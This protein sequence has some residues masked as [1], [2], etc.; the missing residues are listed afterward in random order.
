MTRRVKPKLK[1]DKVILRVGK[2]VVRPGDYLVL[3]TDL[4][5]TK[6]HC[7]QLR[8]LADEQFKGLGV[9]I[10][11]LTSGLKLAVLRKELLQKT[12]KG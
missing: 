3:A 5:L 8:K 6:E 4:F 12:R 11:I 10:A 7:L 9:K 2:L 1:L